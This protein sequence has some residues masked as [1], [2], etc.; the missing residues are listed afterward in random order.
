MFKSFLLCLSQIGSQI[1]HLDLLPSAQAT[2]TTD[3]WP[4]EY[5]N[6]H[7]MFTSIDEVPKMDL[8]FTNKPDWLDGD[9][10]LMGPGKFSW[11]DKTYRGFMDATSMT[12]KISFNQKT[13][14][15]KPDATF[16][17]SMT[18][19]Y[20]YQTN[21]QANSI[22]VSEMMT[23]AEPDDLVTDEDSD[24]EVMK[25]RMDY[26]NDNLSDN[27]IVKVY[28][29]YNKIFQFGEIMTTNVLDE[30]DLSYQFGINLNDA[31]A[32]SDRYEVIIQGASCFT[33]RGNPG[34]FLYVVVEEARTAA[35]A[36]AR[37]TAKTAARTAGA[38]QSA[39]RRRG[40]EA[41]AT[42]AAASSD[43]R[44]ARSKVPLSM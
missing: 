11:G 33:I 17:R 34:A 28:K 38:L 26:Y 12:T 35:K 41:S 13:K 5:P 29:L 27:A 6:V 10:Y 43:L 44:R 20:T 42:T 23:Y 4:N 31:P 19:G 16:Q 32:L 22:M 15:E 37:A 30:E 21:N 8:H 25:K 3:V 24:V 1:F 36:A 14:T 7:N 2:E 40:D 39:P 9:L 18:K